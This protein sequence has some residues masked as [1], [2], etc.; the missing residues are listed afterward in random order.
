MN[1]SDFIEKIVAGRMAGPTSRNRSGYKEASNVLY[2]G[3]HVYSY[4]RHYP[5]L[6]RLETA[7]GIRWILNDRGYS[8]STG[9]HIS[10]ARRYA[11]GAVHLPRI[12]GF[13]RT[14]T[15]PEAIYNATEA[16]TA[17]LYEHIRATREKIAAHPTRRN[18]VYTRSIE[19]AEKRIEDLK[20]VHSIACAAITYKRDNAPLG[21]KPD[22]SHLIG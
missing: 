6:V 8:S 22:V 9:R 15:T 5:L 4:G 17:E 10:H 19:Q 21:G 1:N 2:D 13:D 7:D 16:E 18:T 20:K 14:P 11:D 12:G 3:E